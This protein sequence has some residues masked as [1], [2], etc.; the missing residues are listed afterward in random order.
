MSRSSAS[1]P[2]IG[3]MRQKIL[4][5]LCI[6]AAL[7]IVLAVMTPRFLT[8]DNLLNISRQISTVVTIGAVA[9]L[10][11]VS[12]NFDLSIGGVAALGAALSAT[13]AFGGWPVP[14]AFAAGV[15][16]SAAV[17]A[18]NGALVVVVGINSVIATLGTMFLVGGL[19]LVLTRGLPV[20]SMPDGYALLGRG[21]VGP[22]PMPVVIMLAAVL[23]MIFVERR[24]LLG[25]YARATGSNPDAARVVGLPTRWV[26]FVLFVAVGAAA[27]WGGVMI[28]SRVGGYSFTIGQ[29]LEFQVI[30]AVVLGG[31]SLAGG[32]GTVFGTLLGAFILGSINNGLNLLGVPTFWQ[33]VAL[34][35]TLAV[36]VLI[37]ALLR[38]RM[39]R[40]RATI[41]LVRGPAAAE[42][43]SGAS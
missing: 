21:Y 24:T 43:T 28:S 35:A 22:L 11:Q 5:N 13:L 8:V 34:G 9:T 4:I 12:R 23:L 20:Y 39:K 33:I 27:G 42:A 31:T 32:Q 40:S 7:W 17:G 6:L 18:L 14:V 25:L 26:Q 3:M 38:Q 1:V 41:G 10:L 15:L 29:G 30:V 19:A 36:A 16:A 2:R 37:D